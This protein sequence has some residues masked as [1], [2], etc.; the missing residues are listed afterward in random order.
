M[1]GYSLQYLA[2]YID[3]KVDGDVAYVVHG[4]ASL[5]SANDQNLA[6]YMGRRYEKQ[7]ALTKAACVL[8]NVDDAKSYDG[9]KLIVDNPYLAYAKLS[10]LFVD[11]TTDVAGVHPSAVIANNAA[12]GNNVKVGANAV[13]E[14]NCQ[15]HDNSS[16][17]AGAY[18]GRGVIIG[19]NTIINPNVTI[20]HQVKIGDNCI[21]HSGCVIGADGFGFAP[22]NMGWQKIHQLGSV[23]I[24]NDVEVGANTTIDRGALDDTI[25]D[26]DVKIDNQVQIGHNVTLGRGT[27]IAAKA[28]IAGSVT[29]GKRCRIAG[30]VGI[31]GHLSISDDV[32]ITAMT[33][34]S[35]S[36]PHAGSY[37]SGTKMTT[38]KEWR[39]NAVRFNQLDKLARQLKSMK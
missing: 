25:I 39:K 24:G 9:N 6:L 34:V 23:L 1:N 20:Y 4:L 10:E 32:H 13:I 21:F 17:G 3:A 8:L 11:K 19:Q 36:I 22:S 16:V 38:T 35:K 5:I 12:I 15:I 7:L 14:E 28:A 33:M 30:L 26:G 18:L 27:A 31:A 29:I 37:S 2:E